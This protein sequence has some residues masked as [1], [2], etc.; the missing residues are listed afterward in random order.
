MARSAIC[1]GGMFNCQNFV[2]YLLQLC[3]QGKHIVAHLDCRG[4]GQGHVCSKMANNCAQKPCVLP[5]LLS[6]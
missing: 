4:V 2:V 3:M 1:V 6:S 5:M